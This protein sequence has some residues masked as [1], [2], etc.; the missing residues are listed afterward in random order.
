M[1]NSGPATNGSQFYIT[2]IPTVW[3][4]NK[5]T[6]FGHVVEGQ[7]TVDTVAQGD[8]LESV[9]IVRVG[10]AAQNWNAVEAFRVFE[11]SRAK[12]EAAEREAAKAAKAATRRPSRRNSAAETNS[13]AATEEES[14]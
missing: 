6:V 2:H 12:R 14:A 4:D 10:E 11:G 9:E 8:V 1:A 3:L 5:H 7:D 13:A